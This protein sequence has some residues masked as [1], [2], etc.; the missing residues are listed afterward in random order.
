MSYPSWKNVFQVSKVPLDWLSWLANADSLTKVLEEASGVSCQVAVQQ[1]GWGKPWQDEEDVIVAA[2]PCDC[3]FWIREVVLSARQPAIFARTI[4]PETLVDHFPA[5]AQLGN[6]A[7][8]RVLF[9]D[10]RFQ[11]GPIE[12]AEISV[13]HDLWKHVPE[14]LRVA[15]CW[16][17]RSVFTSD[18]GSLLVS[19]VFLPYVATL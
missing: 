15:Q 13:T 10:N 17:R 4:F 9:A 8:G 6:Q 12:V 18:L 14:R 11:R 5:I 1:E 16:A 2:H 3:S 7:L 19:E